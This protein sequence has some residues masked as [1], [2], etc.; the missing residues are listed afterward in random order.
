[1]RAQLILRLASVFYNVVYRV[2]VFIVYYHSRIYFYGLIVPFLKFLLMMIYETS[3]FE[4]AFYL[5]FNVI[6][7]IYMFC[8]CLDCY[9]VISI[10][11]SL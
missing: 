9:Q 8:G 7:V 3:L 4:F 5:I 11:L 6:N 1:M 2:C 10:F